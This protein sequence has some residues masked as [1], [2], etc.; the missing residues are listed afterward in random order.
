MRFNE[1]AQLDP[2]QVEDQ[3]GQSAGTGGGGF[4][5]PIAVG[6]GGAG[7]LIMLIVVA[8]NVLGG[9]T[10]GPIPS[11]VPADGSA[12]GY[13]G[14]QVAG[15][16]VAQSCHTGADA[17]ARTDCLVVGV[18]NSVQSYW[19]SELSRRGA[20][21]T[22]AD[23]V[24]YSGATQAACGLAQSA[25]G[26]FYCP[27][28]KKVYLDLSFFEDL[29][30]RFGAQGGPFADAYVVAH[31]YGHHV[32]DLLGLVGSARSNTVGQEGGSVRTELQA[33]CLAGVWA[34]HAVQ[35]G[36]VVQLTTADIAAG[37]DAAAAVGDDRIQQETQGR[38]TPD[39][40]THGSA[41]QRQQ[42]FTTGYQYGDLGAC[43]TSKGN[44]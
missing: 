13:N 34:N 33:D 4:G 41:Q 17:N 22:P 31:E 3:R 40:F 7:L 24:F 27:V 11:T 10:S 35:T 29:H 25:E 21:Y 43:D 14:V 32:Q 36:Y 44:V 6:G 37:L 20:T 42:W 12:A 5:M 16:S 26:P 38:V 28:D 39:S 18:V 23:T 8:L 15:A 1:N 30:S 2:T 19:S 9:A